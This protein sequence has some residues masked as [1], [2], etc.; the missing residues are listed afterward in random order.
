EQYD[1]INNAMDLVFEKYNLDLEP[2]P[3]IELNSDLDEYYQNYYKTIMKL[4]EWINLPAVSLKSHYVYKYIYHPLNIVFDDL[5]QYFHLHDPEH[6][7]KYIIERKSWHYQPPFGLLPSA[8]N[9]SREYFNNI[10]DKEENIISEKIIIKG[11]ETICFQPNRNSEPYYG[12]SLYLLMC[13][14]KLPNVSSCDEQIQ[15]ILLQFNSEK[16]RFTW[17]VRE[18]IILT[19][20]EKHDVGTIIEI[21]LIVK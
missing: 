14:V 20:F 12:H 16:L 15:L 9:Q 6:P 18:E 4:L 3:K 10:I 7:A 17:L 11:N 1:D 2:L 13:E 19:S 21:Y 8:F 5:L